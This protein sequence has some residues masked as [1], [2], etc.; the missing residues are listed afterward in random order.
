M[1]LRCHDTPCT[2]GVMTPRPVQPKSWI[3]CSC[4]RQC[5][6]RTGFANHARIC[7]VEQVRSAAF[8]AAIEQGRTDAHAV[9]NEAA[10]AERERVS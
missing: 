1:I 10:R 7:Q 2:V 3:T 6:G 5:R 9:A 4:G 8:I